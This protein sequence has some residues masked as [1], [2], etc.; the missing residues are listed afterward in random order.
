MPPVGSANPVKSV[1]SIKNEVREKE[2][3]VYTTR[4]ANLPFLFL[5]GAAMGSTANWTRSAAPPKNKKRFRE[6]RI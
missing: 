1:L 2:W 5:G 6:H 3:P 4:P